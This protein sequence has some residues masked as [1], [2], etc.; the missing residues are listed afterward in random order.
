[1][2]TITKPLTPTPAKRTAAKPSDA[3]D[4]WGIPDK[5]MGWCDCGAHH[6]VIK[7]LVRSWI[8]EHFGRLPEQLTYL[9]IGEILQVWWNYAE[10]SQFFVDAVNKSATRVNGHVDYDYPLATAAQIMGYVSKTWNGCPV[11]ACGGGSDYLLEDGSEW[12]I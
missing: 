11:E 5:G 2:R 6:P 1:M 4:V 3:P 8:Q 7:D 10:I 9:Q 12:R